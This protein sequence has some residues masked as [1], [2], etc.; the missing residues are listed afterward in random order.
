MPLDNEN[1]PD[2]KNV[3][4][5]IFLVD[6]NPP[7]MGIHPAEDMFIYVKFSA[8]NRNRSDLVETEGE[9]NFIATQVN[10]NDEGEIITNSEGNQK[11]YA[12]TNYTQIGGTVDSSSRGILEGFGI[13]SIDIKYDASLVPRVDITFTDVRGASLF[14]VIDNDNRKSPY[15]IFFKMPYPIFKLSVKGY[16]GKTVDYCLHMLNWTSDFDGSTGDFN[17]S[18]NFVGFQQAF[19]ADM[20][21]GNIIGAVNTKGGLDNLE[22]IYNEQEAED[23]TLEPLPDNVKKIDD[24]FVESSKLQITF[25]DIKKENTE[26]DKLRTLNELRSKL[27]RIQSFVGVPLTKQTGQDETLPYLEQKNKDNQFETS[28]II[29]N[30]LTLGS[31]YLSIRDFVIFN[32]IRLPDIE[33]YFKTLKEITLNYREFLV[34]K[35]EILKNTGGETGSVT[36]DSQKSLL[37]SFK[38]TVT[39]YSYK[40]FLNSTENKIIILEDLFTKLL[41]SNLL[42]EGTPPSTESEINADFDPERYLGTLEKKTIESQDLSLDNAVYVLDF[43]EIRSQIQNTII[44]LS[45]TIKEQQKLVTDQLNDEIKERIGFRPTIENVFRIICN[46]TDAMLATLRTT[47]DTVKSPEIAKKRKAKILEYYGENSDIP[48]KFDQFMWPSVYETSDDK[49]TQEI[50]IGSNEKLSEQLFPEIKFVNDVF[51]NVTGSRKTLNTI[52][53]ATANFAGNDTDNWF[54]INPDDYK[55]NPFL[56]INTLNNNVDFKDKLNEEIVSRINKLNNISQF[57]YSGNTPVNIGGKSSLYM[58]GYL[59][60]INAN[61]TIFSD[62]VRKYITL[63][64]NTTIIKNDSNYLKVKPNNE[65]EVLNAPDE[66]Q[67]SY[68]ILDNIASKMVNNSKSLWG[69]ISTND[70]YKSIVNSSK[71]NTQKYIKSYY[72]NN[73]FTQNIWNYIWYDNVGQNLI[74]EDVKNENYKIQDIYTI[75]ISSNTEGVY[76]NM[77]NTN[78]DIEP[79][80]ATEKY[81]T[82]NDF[83][84]NFT[85]PKDRALLLLS[86]FPF[87]NFKKILDLFSNGYNA[88]ILRIP[89]YYLYYIGALLYRYQNNT[90]TQT[91]WGGASVFFSPREKY[92][93]N[94]GAWNGRKEND[95]NIESA[96]I[97]LPTN[98][99]QTLINKFKN[100]VDFSTGFS[101][102]E[103]NVK[104]YKG[105]DLNITPQQKVEAGKDITNQLKKLSNM[106]LPY[107]KIFSPNIKMKNTISSDDIQNYFNG[108]KESFDGTKNDKGTE[109]NTEKTKKNSNDTENAIK[110]QIYNYFKNINNKWV[111]DDQKQSQVCGANSGLFDYF[112][113]I[114]RGWVDIGDKAVINLDTVLGLS[115]NLDSNIYFFIS[116]LLSKNNFLLQI[117]PTY[118]NYKDPV[119]VSQIFQPITNI[120]DKNKSRGPAYVCIYAGGNSETLDIGENTTYSYPNDGFSFSKGEVPKDFKSDNTTTDEKSDNSLVAF[121]V[122]FGAQNQTIFKNV[123]L[124]QQEHRE[125]A[126]YYKTLTDVIDKRGATQ[127]SYQGSDLLKL[128]KTRSYSCKV[129]AMGCMNIQPLMYFDLQNVPFFNG[130]YLITSVNHS[131]SPNSMT[132]N[133]TGLRQSKFVTPY[134]EQSTAYL[135]VDLEDDLDLEDVVFT[136]NLTTDINFSVGLNEEVQD[137]A[138][139]YTQIT[140]EK[141]TELGVITDGTVDIPTVGEIRTLLNDYGII[142]NSQVT[143]FL[144]NVL[145]NSEN[146]SKNIQTKAE[147]FPNL[148]DYIVRSG[149]SQE[150]LYYDPNATEGLLSGFTTTPGLPIDI[151]YNPY[152][153]TF[154][155]QLLKSNNKLGNKYDGDSWRFR[156]RGYLYIEG[157]DVYTKNYKGGEFGTKPFDIS[158]D[159]KVSFDVACY[160]WTT[161]KDL[162]QKKSSNDWAKEN[163]DSPT[164]EQTTK[165][166]IPNIKERDVIFNKFV[167]VLSTFTSKDGIPLI[168]FE[169][170]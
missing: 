98:T 86:T 3:T 48:A 9:I 67:G 12:T 136:N 131:I 53:Q 140:T 110:L 47:R 82:D 17:I 113:F 141:L 139:D 5:N 91:E 89:T 60:G 155:T 36:E 108:F 102:L 112:K 81:L 28:P 57:T 93:S 41:S 37:E 158:N 46:N 164:F 25:E 6:P 167:Q 13:K 30:S 94:L 87:Q 58:Y 1:K 169:R 64:Y 35:N 59:E 154:N 153:D 149:S 100:W 7:G 111:S 43:R 49:G 76:I 168:S 19:L 103:S 138:F 134:V 85:E 65:F 148:E 92:I 61:K 24:F 45:K 105:K 14:D 160:V 109:T 127:R 104:I 2:V 124:S 165:L 99:K 95:F 42:T 31:D 8:F 26:L 20:V 101:D 56:S 123:S 33:D 122:G 142:T 51:N 77:L 18:A 163:G 63:N 78:P 72:Y 66:E 146:L 44:D 128:F 115:N 29:D 11:T 74:K 16:F 32:A 161:V 116:T 70:F 157:R 114:D 132:T 83:Y 22:S 135:N 39:D 121:K 84:N 130:A 79:G 38:T 133:F 97:N 145:V 159:S 118:I 156:K 144:T 73:N 150:T 126:E 4:S 151:V 68:I 55:T 80:F 90:M 10:Y 62:D 119:E 166:S 27:L 50:Y 137:E 71:N 40:T 54:P 125:T 34:D 106:V 52:T 147:N 23:E 170:P 143:M 162:N 69:E 107:P 96:L 120:S 88:R 117:L 75:D 152:G 21:L 15:S 129:D